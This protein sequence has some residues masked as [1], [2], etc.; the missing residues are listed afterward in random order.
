M[1]T[2]YLC[3]ATLPCLLAG[4]AQAADLTYYRHAQAVRPVTVTR[5]AAATTCPPLP[6]IVARFRRVIGEPGSYYAKWDWRFFPTC[7]VI[8]GR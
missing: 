2:A 8:I 4:A 5:V 3:L 7:D 6:A 1:R